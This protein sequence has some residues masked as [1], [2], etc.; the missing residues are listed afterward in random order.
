MLSIGSPIFPTK[1]E[2][3]ADASK[4]FNFCLLLSRKLNKALKNSKAFN[5]TEVLVSKNHKEIHL[6][7][8]SKD[9]ITASEYSV[10]QLIRIERASMRNLKSL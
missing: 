7:I 8:I 4:L 2:I 1:Y 10:T 9:F 5:K 6:S 3:N